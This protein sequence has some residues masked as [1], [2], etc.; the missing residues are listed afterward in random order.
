M[1]WLWLLLMLVVLMLLLVLAE[2][3]HWCWL[4]LSHGGWGCI[5]R[6]K[7]ARWSQRKRGR[8]LSLRLLLLE[9]LLLPLD[10]RV[11]SHVDRL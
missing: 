5:S 7:A 9:L 10:S 2:L 8:H 11:L 6:G 4:L 3:A 1:L